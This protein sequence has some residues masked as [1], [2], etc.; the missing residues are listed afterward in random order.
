M[1]WSRIIKNLS[2]PKLSSLAGIQP[3]QL[4][5][6]FSLRSDQPR[7][8]RFI[9]SYSRRFAPTPTPT[10]TGAAPEPAS[11][12]SRSLR[13]E[14]PRPGRSAASWTAPGRRFSRR[15]SHQVPQPPGRYSGLRP[16]ALQK[17]RSLTLQGPIQ[18]I[19]IG[20]GGEL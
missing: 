2:S 13:T 20:G 5:E 10:P 6:S 11:P 18:K 15:H 3:V 19:C 17:R 4:F 9:Y 12:A 7:R 14:T 16:G 1:P 8:R